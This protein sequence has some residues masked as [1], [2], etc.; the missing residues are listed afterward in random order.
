GSQRSLTGQRHLQSVA[1][2][3]QLPWRCI[4]HRTDRH[5]HATLVLDGHGIGLHFHLVGRLWVVAWRHWCRDGGRLLADTSSYIHHRGLVCH[6]QA[7][8]ELECQRLHCGCNQ[9]DTNAARIF[10]CSHHAGWHIRAFDNSDPHLR[11]W[12]VL[13]VPGGRCSLLS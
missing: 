5:H 4:H 9:R 1:E 11:L 2:P 10:H 6:G 8:P 13:V 3:Y 7:L 12:L